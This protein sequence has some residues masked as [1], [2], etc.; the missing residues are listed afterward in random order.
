MPSGSYERKPYMKNSKGKGIPLKVRNWLLEP[1]RKRI[2][3]LLESGEMS[4]IAIAGRLQ[5]SLYK[6]RRVAE[7]MSRAAG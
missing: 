3:T 6:V 1:E 7:E 4:R 5:V 2:K